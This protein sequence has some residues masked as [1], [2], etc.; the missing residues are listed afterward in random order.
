M[1]GLSLLFLA[2]VFATAQTSGDLK[3]EVAS[4]KLA[5]PEHDGP[6]VYRVSPGTD[7]PERITFERQNMMRLLGVATG[8]DWDQIS[9]PQWV[10]TG[11]S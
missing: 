4:V 3:F 11:R 10:A 6:S 5:G 9:A 1:R 7:D 2:A 8:F